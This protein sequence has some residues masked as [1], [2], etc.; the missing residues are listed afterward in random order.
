MGARPPRYPPNNFYCGVANANMAKRSRISERGYV[1]YRS[2]IHLDRFSGFLLGFRGCYLY[3]GGLQTKLGGIRFRGG[4]VRLGL[5]RRIILGT[6]FFKRAKQ[7]TF[8][9][10]FL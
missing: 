2:G 1:L 10:A 5:E 7:E 9:F 3:Y 4:F 8:K 6:L